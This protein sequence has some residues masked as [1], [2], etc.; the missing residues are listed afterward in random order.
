MSLDP[1]VKSRRRAQLKAIRAFLAGE[2]PKLMSD[3]EA[4]CDEVSTNGVAFMGSARLTRRAADKMLKRAE[5]LRLGGAC[6]HGA[7]K[8]PNHCAEGEHKRAPKGLEVGDWYYRHS[9]EPGLWF[10]APVPGYPPST[11][12]FRVTSHSMS[13]VTMKKGIA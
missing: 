8:G 7:D 6:L 4:L 1:A 12:R 5:R 13:M 3:V 10:K 11:G 2:M 9:G